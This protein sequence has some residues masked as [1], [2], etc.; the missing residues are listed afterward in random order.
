MYGGRYCGKE[1][2]L[3]PEYMTVEIVRSLLRRSAFVTLGVGMNAPPRFAAHPIKGWSLLTP[4][5][6]DSSPRLDGEVYGLAF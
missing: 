2:C 3:S 4:K 1:I 6:S 5:V